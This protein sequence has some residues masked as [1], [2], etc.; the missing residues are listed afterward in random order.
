MD[1]ENEQS[2]QQP[3][4]SFW[5]YTLSSFLFENVNEINSY[6][7]ILLIMLYYII[8]YYYYI[9]YIYIYITYLK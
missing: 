6:T 9:I 7:L 4:D 3:I 2:L 5:Y 8:L 1:T